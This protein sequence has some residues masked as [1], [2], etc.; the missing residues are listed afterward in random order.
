METFN[1]QNS[2]L[3]KKICATLKSF[4]HASSPPH[5]QL[6]HTLNHHDHNGDREK[7]TETCTNLIPEI[8]QRK[9]VHE[10]QEARLVGKPT[11]LI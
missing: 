7:A 5:I 11:R 1:E 2:R 3:R 10:N 8:T 4:D 6:P 9:T